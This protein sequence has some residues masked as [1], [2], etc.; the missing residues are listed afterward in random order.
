MLRDLRSL[1]MPRHEREF[2]KVRCILED[3]G[4]VHMSQEDVDYMCVR[5]SYC[6]TSSTT[7]RHTDMSHARVTSVMHSFCRQYIWN[8]SLR[9]F[10]R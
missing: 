6:M 1:T 9:T 8:C 7:Q 10:M 4:R 2:K 5:R 3:T